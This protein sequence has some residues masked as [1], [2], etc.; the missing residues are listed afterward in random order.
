[1]TVRAADV[2]KTVIWRCRTGAR[3]ASLGD[4]R[5]PQAILDL[6][7]AYLSSP[8]PPVDLAAPHLTRS[9]WGFAA[10]ISR[11]RTVTSP[12]GA[13][14]VAH[15]SYHQRHGAPICGSVASV[16]QA[17]LGQGGRC[18]TLISVAACASRTPSRLS[19]LR[20]TPTGCA[21]SPSPQI[22]SRR[23]AA[24]AAASAGASAI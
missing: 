20:V 18:L 1:M 14:L 9:W 3:V 7:H 15:A 22:P 21:T 17:D 19:F 6:G 4:P 10:F 24:T 5:V 8:S 11:A 12:R 13:L 16:P 2:H 23:G